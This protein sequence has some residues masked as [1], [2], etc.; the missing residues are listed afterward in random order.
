MEPES[1]PAPVIVKSKHDA[2][3]IDGKP[4]PTFDPTP[5]IGRTF[6]L[7]PEDDGQ[8]FRGKIIEVLQKTEKDLTQHPARVKFRCSIN[9]NEFEE[10]LSYNDIMDLI[11]KDETE[12]GLWKFKSISG[13]QGPLS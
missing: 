13:H 3:L 8:R 10:I 6:L 9:N 7:P 11:E 5:L 2:D 12:H 1:L 4:M